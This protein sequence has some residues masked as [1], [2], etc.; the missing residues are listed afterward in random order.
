MQ[1]KDSQLIFEAYLKAYVKDDNLSQKLTE[2]RD[3]D[4]Q[5]ITELLQEAGWFDKVKQ[6]GSNAA[7]SVG[8]AVGGAAKAVGSAVGS[9]AKAIGNTSVG[10]AVKQGVSKI[11]QGVVQSL[12]NT[13][14]SKIAPD[15]QKLFIDLISGKSKMPA[16]QVQAISKQVAATPIQESINS[17]EEYKRWL[18]H[19]LFTESNLT[20]ALANSG[21]LLEA[22]N[23]GALNTIAKEM[24]AKIQALYPKNKKAMA[25]ALPKVTAALHNSLGVPQQA[26]QAMAAADGKQ[27][28]AAATGGQT[29]AGSQAGTGAQSGTEAG[30]AGAQQTAPGTAPSAGLLKT[31]VTI[32]TKYPKM[33]AV[34][35]AGLLGVAVVAFKAVG[36]V[37]MLVLCLSK[38]SWA[39]ATGAAS[40]VARQIMAGQQVSGKQVAKDA[41]ISGAVGAVGAVLGTGL[42]S[43]GQAFAGMF[44]GGVGG[45]S[46]QLPALERGNSG[47]NVPEPGDDSQAKTAK[48]AN[49]FKYIAEPGDNGPQYAQGSAVEQVAANN[50][51]FKEFINSPQG[52]G[53]AKQLQGL[54]V[55]E[56]EKLARQRSFTVKG[57]DGNTANELI[58][59][60]KASH[61]MGDETSNKQSSNQNAWAK[62][63]ERKLGPVNYTKDIAKAL[64][65][66]SADFE[67]RQGVP[68]DHN[69]NR[70]PIDDETLQKLASKNHIGAVNLDAGG[71]TNTSTKGSVSKGP[72]GN[73]SRLNN[74]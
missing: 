41:A 69:G 26:A 39:G 32:A 27:A 49:T 46:N 57:F 73:V 25:A 63:A 30:S 17:K 70:L 67:L 4:I 19:T 6:W 22:S 34:T 55:N 59:A 56:I 42:T 54:D 68:Y 23:A 20:N 7:K 44:K 29:G 58:D 43:L 14:I 65:M 66:K 40:S 36:I 28:P 53:I 50:P 60:A 13:L 48:P 33:S 11:T 12:V 37:P 51:K 35:A 64:N 31:L 9:A 52:A 15:Q 61:E 1:N 18:A 47:P 5:C 45:A 3:Y 38:A 72:S 71:Q 10:Q 21:L 24:A 74:L 8:N 62:Y 16:D 2:M